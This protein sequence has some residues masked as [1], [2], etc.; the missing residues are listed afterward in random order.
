M[1]V[2]IRIGD[3][4]QVM[5]G[6]RN[7]NRERPATRGKVVAMDRESGLVTVEKYN[8]RTKHLRR[9]QRHPGGGLVQR[10]APVHVS[11]VML[12]ASDGKPVRLSRAERVDGKV[13]RRASAGPAA[14]GATKG[15]PA[16][17][18]AGS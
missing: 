1:S 2:S 16:A 13:V 9:S 4:V 3:E 15:A 5:S 8:L 7:R 6:S 18:A 17:G 12:V 14:G 11:R 10:E